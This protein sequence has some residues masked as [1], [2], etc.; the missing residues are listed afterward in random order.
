[1]PSLGPRIHDDAGLDGYNARAAARYP[2]AC[3]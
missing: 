2:H 1:V 3:A